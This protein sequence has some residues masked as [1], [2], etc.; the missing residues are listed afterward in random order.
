M[1][2]ISNKSELGKHFQPAWWST[3][4]GAGPEEEHKLLDYD[5]SDE[6]E[7]KDL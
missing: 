4:G 7:A 2:L 5:G 6:E 3:L 1:T